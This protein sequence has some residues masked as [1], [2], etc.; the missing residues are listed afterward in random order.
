MELSMEPLTNLYSLFS[1]AGFKEQLLRIASVVNEKG[2]RSTDTS[3]RLSFINGQR[4]SMLLLYKRYA[5]AKN[6]CHGSTT[7]WNCRYRRRG[8]PAC[9]A[10]LSTKKLS[11]GTYRVDLKQPQHNH[12]PSNRIERRLMRDP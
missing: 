2:K 1:F 8:M 12:S 9:N 3:P 10:R 7:Y 5:Y 6:N 4:N 11:D